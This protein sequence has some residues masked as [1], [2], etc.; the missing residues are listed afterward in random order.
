MAVEAFAAAAFVT[1]F[2]VRSAVGAVASRARL[3][4]FEAT[5]TV[6]TVTD[7]AF[8]KHWSQSWSSSP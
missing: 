1:T 7:A 3:G 5:V 4:R 8:G 2:G 6:V